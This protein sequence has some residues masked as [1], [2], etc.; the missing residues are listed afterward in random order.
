YQNDLWVSYQ[1]EGFATYW[2]PHLMGPLNE[3]PNPISAMSNPPPGTYKGGTPDPRDLGDVWYFLCPVTE[4]QKALHIWRDKTLAEDSPVHGTIYD[5][6]FGNPAQWMFCNR[7]QHGH[8]PGWGRWMIHHFNENARLSKDAMTDAIG[9]YAAQGTEC[10]IENIIDVVDFFQSRAVAG[11]QTTFEGRPQT[12][13]PPF[14]LPPGQGVE[15]VPFFEAVYHDHGPVIEDGWGQL[16][17]EFGEIFYWIASRVVTQFGGVFELNYEFGWPEKLPDWDG[18]P[19]ATFIPYDGAYWEAI[20]PPALDPAKA[21]FLAEV[22]TARVGFGNPW[23]GYGRI[24]RPPGT[25]SDKVTL[26]YFHSYDWLNYTEERRGTWDVFQLME[27]AWMD[28]D[29]RLGLFFVN[30]DKDQDF[31]LQVNVDATERWGADYRGRKLVMSTSDGSRDIGR[32]GRDN[33]IRFSLTLPPRQIT[34]I[35][36]DGPPR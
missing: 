27:A 12:G 13:G 28:P 3:F 2:E 18:T 5:V 33:R 29:D 11:P 25:P 34:L 17:P 16:S 26:D 24:V 35:A 15:V 4:P 31:Q 14:E 8:T 22:A 1:S 21:A 7:G 23:L 30:V 20:E 19:P 10:V 6:S 32:V 36:V 9:R